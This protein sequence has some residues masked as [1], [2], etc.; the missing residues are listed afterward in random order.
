MFNINDILFDTYRIQKSLRS[1]YENFEKFEVKDLKQGKD[2]I[3]KSYINS[4]FDYDVIKS[5][6]KGKKN[7]VSY[8]ISEEFKNIFI[9]IKDNVMIKTPSTDDA[10]FID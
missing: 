8:A 2:L 6:K 7:E 10:E 4:Y 5:I 3:L 9:M 1:D